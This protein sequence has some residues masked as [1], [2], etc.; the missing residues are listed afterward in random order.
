MLQIVCTVVETCAIQ[1]PYMRCLD[2]IRILML[3]VENYKLES[4]PVL[5]LA[6]GPI[7]EK[8]IQTPAVQ[9]NRSDDERSI[10]NLNSFLVK[11]V[12]V[13][14]D[15]LGPHFVFCSSF[16]PMIAPTC[17][18]LIESQ[19]QSDSS[20]F[21]KK[22]A[23][24]AVQSLKILLTALRG[25]IAGMATERVQMNLFFSSRRAQASWP[26]TPINLQQSYTVFP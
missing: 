17:N 9:S 7:L 18:W 10:L 8:A 25:N 4:I 2:L 12:H 3:S 24:K 23:T 5:Q 13:C 1:L 6:L 21:D 22:N 20:T 26:Q 15:I 11:L 14:L 19:I 16:A